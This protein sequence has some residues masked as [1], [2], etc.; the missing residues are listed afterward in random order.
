MATT[1]ISIV[2]VEESLT[3]TRAA[4]NAEGRPDLLLPFYSLLMLLFLLYC[5]PIARAT[6]ALERRTAV[7]S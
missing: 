5:Y 4:L 2:G 7:K 6:L 1:L 3:Y